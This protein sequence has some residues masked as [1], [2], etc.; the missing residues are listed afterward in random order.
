MV[1]VANN[2]SY[3]N[4]ELHQERVASRRDRPVANRWIGQRLDDPAIA[5]PALARSLGLAAPETVRRAEDLPEALARAIAVVEGGGAI[6]LDV[7][8]DPGY[9]S[10]MVAQE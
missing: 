1:V 6:V 9:A 10:E 2:R 7:E 3:F 4:D 8:I 5:I